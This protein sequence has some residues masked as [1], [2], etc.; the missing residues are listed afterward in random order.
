MVVNCARESLNSQR[1]DMSRTRKMLHKLAALAGL[2]TLSLSATALDSDATITINRALNSPTL[3]IRYTGATAS[4]AELMINGESYGTRVLNDSITSGETNFTLGMTVLNEGENQI[5]VRLFDKNGSLVGTQQTTVMA[6]KSKLA[7][8]FISSPKVGQTLQGP[9]ELKVGF[10]RELKNSYVSFFVDNQ[11]KLMT[12]F[13]PYNY[14]WDTMRENNGWHEVEAWVVDDTSATFKTKKVRIFVNNPGGHTNRIFT[15][16]TT[17]VKPTAQ[18]MTLQPSANPGVAAKAGGEAGL[19]PTAIFTAGA[20]SEL[21]TPSVPSIY[22]DVMANP[23]SIG[24]TVGAMS[25]LKPSSLQPVVATGS[26]NLTPTGTRVAEPISAPVVL[27]TIAN[28]GLPPVSVTAPGG[29]KMSTQPVATKLDQPVVVTPKATAIVMVAV[30]KPM[31]TKS[32]ATANTQPVAVKSTGTP[33]VRPVIVSGQPLTPRAVSISKPAL[34]TP[35][36]KVSKTVTTLIKVQPGFRIPHKGNYAVVMDGKLVEFDVQPRVDDGV[37]MTPFRH[38]VEK[39]GGTVN[40]ENDS[41]SVTANADGRSIMLQIGTKI[42]TI[43]N[44]KVEMELAP[45]LDKNR[46]IVPL[47]FMRDSL[48]VNIEYDRATNHVLITS[49]KN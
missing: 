19:R 35:V 10:G 49:I 3:T 44:A 1:V 4:L 5:E 12:N 32:S 29:V 28:P 6:N 33:A 14:M 16:P 41:K 18:P 22:G 39:R 47:S 45:Y 7:D 9:V 20:S 23:A 30:A 37:P 26:R 11:F 36:V 25:Y 38:L 34:A 15:K 43:D 24:V 46:T 42:A 27:K 8:V 17:P 21:L 40:W 48:H 13:P 2:L 31:I